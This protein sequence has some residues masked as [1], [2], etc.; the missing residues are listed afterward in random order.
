MG[1]LRHLKWLTGNWFYG[2][3]SVIQKN[4]GFSGNAP[5]ILRFWDDI[6][7]LRDASASKNLYNINGCLGNGC[8][9]SSLWLYKDSISISLAQPPAFGT[10]FCTFPLRC[11]CHFQKIPGF[12]AFTPK[13]FSN[14]KLIGWEP[15]LIFMTGSDQKEIFLLKGWILP[16]FTLSA[17]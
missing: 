11:E 3:K 8:G 4:T 5:W 12:L 16:I 1:P 9:E 14:A 7:D 6:C 10:C 13:M 17:L 2:V 15:W